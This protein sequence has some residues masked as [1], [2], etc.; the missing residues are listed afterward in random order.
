MKNRKKRSLKKWFYDNILNRYL[1]EFHPSFILFAD[2][3][4][5]KTENFNKDEK[6]AKEYKRIMKVLNSKKYRKHF[7]KIVNHN[8]LIGTPAFEPFK[9]NLREKFKRFVA[10]QYLRV[11]NK[12]L[13][14]SLVSFRSLSTKLSKID[15]QI[16]D[17]MNNTTVGERIKRA[18]DVGIISE[19]NYKDS[20]EVTDRANKAYQHYISLTK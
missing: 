11:F 12:P 14:K 1:I 6:N 7:Y 2:N 16:D 13:Y 15:S 4:S 3:L 8:P 19:D 17:Y 18:V 9:D 10:K 20:N 5:F